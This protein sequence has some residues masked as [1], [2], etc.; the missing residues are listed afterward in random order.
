MPQHL[1]PRPPLPMTSCCPDSRMD[2]WIAGSERMFS[3]QLC[4]QLRTLS[5]FSLPLMYPTI[6]VVSRA[7]ADSSPQRS[8]LPHN[9]RCGARP[10][11]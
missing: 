4:A 2:T 3:T 1:P 7:V 10:R 5:P 11:G 8:A 6:A 9:I